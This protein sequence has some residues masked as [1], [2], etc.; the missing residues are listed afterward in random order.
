[1]LQFVIVSALW[2]KASGLTALLQNKNNAPW[3]GVR[4]YFNELKDLSG[5]INDVAGEFVTCWIVND[6]LYYAVGFSRFSGVLE[7]TFVAGGLVG[8]LVNLYFA[9][10]ICYKVT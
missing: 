1:M 6:M 7:A 3:E 5:F 10:D 8:F 4:L 2:T 9:A